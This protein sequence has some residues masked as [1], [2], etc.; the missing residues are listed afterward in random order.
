MEDKFIVS[1][2]MTQQFCIK[3]YTFL[4]N[5]ATASSSYCDHIL[6]QMSGHILCHTTGFKPVVHQKAKYQETWPNSA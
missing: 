5:Y 6:K 4:V 1:L 2:E 3:P